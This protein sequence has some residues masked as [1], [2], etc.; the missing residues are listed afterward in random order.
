M[1]CTSAALGTGENNQKKLNNYGPDCTV[2][3]ALKDLVRI[4]CFWA[5]FASGG[6]DIQSHPPAPTLSISISCNPA[7]CQAR[8]TNTLLGRDQSMSV[9]SA[10]QPYALFGQFF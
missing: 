6:K 3:L 8:L 2:M 9:P 4:G 1:G 7:L 5:W 10:S